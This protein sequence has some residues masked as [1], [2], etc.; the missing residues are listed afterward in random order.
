MPRNM[1]WVRNI[2]RIEREEIVGMASDLRAFTNM[3]I[4]PAELTADLSAFADDM[5]TIAGEAAE[6]EKQKAL[7]RLYGFSRFLYNNGK[8]IVGL[9][10]PDMAESFRK[11]SEKIDD[12]FALRINM[13]GVFPSGQKEAEEDLPGNLNIEQEISG[14]S[15]EQKVL[16]GYA[17]FVIRKMTMEELANAPEVL[18]ARQKYL[19]RCQDEMK[20]LSEMF[21]TKKS[22][23]LFNWNSDLYNRARDT[24]D[25]YLKS[26]DQA[27]AD[28]KRLPQD[29]GAKRITVEV[30]TE[31]AKKIGEHVDRAMEDLR[32]DMRAYAVH[33]TGGKGDQL[34]DLGVDGKTQATGAARLA[35]STGVLALLGRADKQIG[36]EPEKLSET[37]EKERVN[38][39]NF[40]RLYQ[41]QFKEIEKG[42][43]RHRRAASFAQTS[44]ELAN[45]D[46]AKLQK[47]GK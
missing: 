42:S 6:K 38:E 27:S 32:R 22:F 12:K 4:L 20:A 13:T 1:D 15:E 37:R 23:R 33:A 47:L 16:T 9:L 17:P 5:E 14:N 8:R 25:A 36:I 41:K 21:H 34:G 35:A 43:D 45:K 44:R 11:L 10:E 39:I 3:E 29:L 26:V 19:M 31:A 24:L 46:A 28:Y 7:D 30:Y 18:G 2:A 40:H